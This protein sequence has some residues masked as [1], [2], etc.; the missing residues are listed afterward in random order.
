MRTGLTITMWAAIGIITFHELIK[1]QRVP[2]PENYK[3]IAII[4]AT[5]GVVAE[6]GAYDIATAMGMGIIIS[7]MYTY[8]T[9][10]KPPLTSPTG[11]GN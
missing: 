10:K 7:M 6:L 3:Y 9:K 4:W 8:V 5:L 2:R 11:G 1:L